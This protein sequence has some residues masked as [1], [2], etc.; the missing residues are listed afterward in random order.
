MGLLSFG[1]TSAEELSQIPIFPAKSDSFMLVL[2]LLLLEE[3]LVGPC[4]LE[5]RQSQSVKNC[6]C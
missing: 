1:R 3:V 4:I 6:C 2:A 5:L